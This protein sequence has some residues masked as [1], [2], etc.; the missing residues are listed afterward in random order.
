M[1]KINFFSKHALS[2]S[3]QRMTSAQ[4]W[5]PPGFSES[6]YLFGLLIRGDFA[7]GRFLRQENYPEN[8]ESAATN[9]IQGT[10]QDGPSSQTFFARQWIPAGQPGKVVAGRNAGRYNPRRV[11]F[12]HSL[13]VNPGYSKDVECDMCSETF[14]ESR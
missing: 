14:L 7:L 5:L 12:L 1:E 8:Y 10:E 11:P 9:R 2:S 4:R 13:H 6:S 3:T